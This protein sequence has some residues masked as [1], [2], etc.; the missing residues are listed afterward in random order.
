MTVIPIHL[1]VEDD[2]SE[3]LLR[4]ILGTPAIAIRCWTGL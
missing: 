3:W 2:L 1:A 4:R